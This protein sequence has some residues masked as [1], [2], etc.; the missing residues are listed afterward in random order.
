M[1]RNNLVLI[2]F[3]GTGKSTIGMRLAEKLNWTFK[4]TDLEIE[5]AEGYTVQELFSARGEPTFR[6]ME[7]AI[8]K[9]I[10]S[11]KRQVVATG[12]GCVLAEGN[13]VSM[14]ES[15]FVVSLGASVETIVSRVEGVN[16]RPL[17][18]GDIREKVTELIQRRMG[19]YGF[20]HYHVDTDGRE[21]EE[22]ADLIIREFHKEPDFT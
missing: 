19:V 5:R 20:A 2:G 16:N 10:L 18:A 1:D 21:P 8:L 22:I 17:L 9:Q 3:M 11:E 6:E 12:G 14:Q 13:R 7:S 4:D 15:G